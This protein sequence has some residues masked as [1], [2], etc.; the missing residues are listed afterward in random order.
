MKVSIY[1]Q[2]GGRK[3]VSAGFGG[4][5]PTVTGGTRMMRMVLLIQEGSAV[6]IAGLGGVVECQGQPA[7]LIASEVNIGEVGAED[8]FFFRALF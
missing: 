7:G 2:E 1:R 6:S 5:V 4:G 8:A 3:A